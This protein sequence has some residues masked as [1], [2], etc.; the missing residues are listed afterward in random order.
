VS[1][2]ARRF[3]GA[4]W[5]FRSLNGYPDAMRSV[6]AIILGGGQGARLF[7]LTQLRSKPAVP[8]GGK[9]RL[10]D[11]PISNCLHADIRRIYV[12]TQFNSASLNRHVSS[13]Y[14]MD[15]FS[16]GFVEILAA[17]QTPESAAWFEGTADAVRKARRHFDAHPA[18]H[19]LILAGDHLYRMNYSDLLDA[20][21]ERRADIT[22]AAQPCTRDDATQMGI[23]VF[24]RSGQITAFEEKPTTRRLE[25]METSFPHGFDAA[26]SDLAPADDKP[27]MASMGIYMFSRRVLLEMLEQEG[28]DFGRQLIPTALG[29]YR[30]SAYMHSGYWADVGT[31][32]NFYDA[33]IQ[34]TQPDAPFSFYDATCPI[35]THQR[36]LPPSR[37]LECDVHNGLVA[38]GSYLDRCEVSDSVV[39]IRSIINQGTRIRRSVLLGADFYETSAAAAASEVPLGVGPGV[40]IDCAIIDKNA[41]IGEGARLVN[42]KNVDE[43]DGDGFYIRN[44][45]II[46]PKGGVIPAGFEVS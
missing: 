34:L 42:R 19:Y 44:G 17:E 2:A 23:F 18:S 41:R 5:R 27:F 3:T 4:V 1:P 9:Y 12:L 39:G 28:N 38:D 29:R 25:E 8:I 16:T 31:V 37:L 26:A 6:L 10:I 45:I 35:Y 24:D 36:F 20:H 30:V 21:V 14:Q 13:T 22:I 15:Q 11:V 43:H 7:P 33:N 46:V 40:E 32:E